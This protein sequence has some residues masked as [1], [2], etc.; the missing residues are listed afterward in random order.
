MKVKHDSFIIFRDLDR[1]QIQLAFQVGKQQLG[2]RA[3][4]VMGVEG[5]GRGTV[6][7][8]QQGG[9]GFQVVEFFIDFV[10][11]GRGGAVISPDAIELQH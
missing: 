8:A 4:G 1:Q 6:R 3:A 5:A 9:R 2:I 11:L 7:R 10:E